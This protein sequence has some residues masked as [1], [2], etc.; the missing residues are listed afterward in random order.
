MAQTAYKSAA[1]LMCV[2]TT[3]CVVAPSGPPPG[4]Y[5]ETCRNVAVERGMLM[6]DCLRV[7]GSVNRSAL[8]LDRCYRAPVENQDGQ[9]VC[10]GSYGYGR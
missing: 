10:A 7:D 3:G 2:V 4:S 5:L 6:A 9:L 1:L 8:D